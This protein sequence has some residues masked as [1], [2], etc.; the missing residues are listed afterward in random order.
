MAVSR[1]AS[2]GVVAWRGSPALAEASGLELPGALPD[3]SRGNSEGSRPASGSSMAARAVRAAEIG[4]GAGAAFGAGAGLG[5]GGASGRSDNAGDPSASAVAAGLPGISRIGAGAGPGFSPRGSRAPTGGR[6]GGSS[7]LPS[8]NGSPPRA[9]SG[10]GRLASASSAPR[11]PGGAVSSSKAGAARISWSRS[12]DESSGGSEP[13]AAMPGAGVDRSDAG[14]S[15]PAVGDGSAAAVPPSEPRCAAGF[16]A[17]ADGEAAGLG[18]WVMGGRFPGWIAHTPPRIASERAV[19]TAARGYCQAIRAPQTTA[20]AASPEATPKALASPAPRDRPGAELALSL[21]SSSSSPWSVSLAPAGFLASSSPSPSSSQAS[22]PGGARWLSVPVAEEDDS[23]PAAAA[24]L[25]LRGDQVGG[26]AAVE[27]AEEGG[28]WAA[29]Q[30]KADAG[31]NSA[32]DPGFPSTG[33]IEAEASP[34]LTGSATGAGGGSPSVRAWG[35]MF[36]SGL[37]IARPPSAWRYALGD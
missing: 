11:A 16:A 29:V 21:S 15:I 23:P 9:G 18:I 20:A 2:G 6:G 37:Y 12:R 19:A 30:E 22:P 32:T 28:R 14:A 8:S 17:G 33:G 35:E 7:G 34:S 31:G 3:S 26:W 10:A 24:E 5:A 25:P 4:F 13:T 36:Q 1:G 27:E